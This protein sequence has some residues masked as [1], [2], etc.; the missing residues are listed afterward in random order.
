MTELNK[1]TEEQVYE[2]WVNNDIFQKS[3]EVNKSKK[4]FKF[5][6]GPPFMSG[7]M[8]YG[9]ILAGMIKDSVLRYFHN[10]GFQVYRY[11]SIDCHGL[12]I[13]YEIEK[14][15]GIKT[16]QQVL[17]YGIKNY[18]N[19]CE[20]IVL[21]C[22]DK[23]EEQNGRLGRW[24]DYKNLFKTMDLNFMNSVWWVFAELYKKNRVYE[25]VR[26]MPYSTACGTPLSNFE[27]GQNYK[28][29]QDDSLYVKFKII[30]NEDSWLLCNEYSN[31]YF[32]VWTTTPWTLPTNYLLAINKNMN[33]KTIPYF[34]KETNLKELLIV[35]EEKVDE[36]R[37]ILKLGNDLVS[38]HSLR[39]E[40]LIGLKYEPLFTF[41]NLHNDYKVIHADY[42]S[43]TTGTGIVHISPTHG[44]ED[45]KACLENNYITKESKLFTT[46]DANGYIN[47]NIPEL[48]GA[49]YKNH[50]KSDN[51]DL[52]TWVIKRLKENNQFLLKKTIN[53]EYPFCWR[54]DTPLIYN[55]VNSWFVR[56]EDMREKLVELNN[57]INWVPKSVGES[58][59]S[60]WL[61]DARDWGIS[62]NRF[63]GTP[64]P[65]WKSSTGKIICISSS[66]ELERLA[67]LDYGSITN[68][69]RQFVDEIEIK[70][71]GE[72][73][74]RVEFVF[75][76][77]LESGAMPYGTVGKV[78][79]V[80]LLE[81]HCTKPDSGLKFDSD[82]NPYIQTDNYIYDDNHTTPIREKFSIL[83]ADFIAEGLDQTRG[84]FYTL[85]VLSASL[86]DMISFKN[87]IVNGLILAEDG[88][89]M[90]KRLKNY[91][92]PMDI[93]K[94]YGSDALRLY[95]LGS[96]ATKAEALKFTKSGVHETMKDIIIPLSNTIIFWKEYA[97]LYVKTHKSNPVFSLKLNQSKINNPINLWI[98]KKYSELRLE[99][100]SW[101]DKYELKNSVGILY[102]LVQILNNGYIKMGRNF[103]KG[104][105]SKE[106]WEESLSVMSY[107]IGFVLNDFKSIIPFFC[108]S[109]YLELK[110]F[111]LNELNLT[112]NFDE[113]IHL[114][115]SQE[116]IQLN[117]KQEACS[118][119]FDIIYN[120]I[121]QIYQLRSLND[122]SLKKPV[123]SVQLMWDESLEMRY[124]S[125][126][127]NYLNMVCEECN[128]LNLELIEK[129]QVKITKTIVPVKA[130]FF[131]KYGKSVQDFYELLMSL[132]SEKLEEIIRNNPIDYKS[133]MY[134]IDPTMFNYTYKI[135]LM[136]LNNNTANSNNLIYREFNFGPSKDKIVLLMDKTWDNSTDKIYYYRLI[137]TSIQKARKEARLHPWDKI[138][139]LWEGEPKYSLC[140]NEALEYIEKITRIKLS[141]Y[142]D[143]NSNTIYSE[144]FE[145]I[146][147]KIYLNKLTN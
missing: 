35:V 17:D 49:F 59:F 13:E 48:K 38:I 39:G 45:Y 131:K 14:E 118:V 78:G 110:D 6:D 61:G 54:S 130:L 135:E 106:E 67:G 69:H 96:Q 24:L 70:K 139:A 80:E 89:K 65:I 25:G 7:E 79:I 98:L 4:M 109:K 100:I 111:Y 115:E 40:E 23:W 12:P 19:A 87:V 95:L 145:N 85:L 68:L 33:Y 126:F 99:F 91:P 50:T 114:V 92:D 103:I 77:W 102:K 29:I 10:K 21:R 127:K 15:L 93:V 90:S 46:L 125:K 137:A 128:L 146:G 55:A 113:S 43:N 64:I 82:N 136:E 3:N 66:Y 27:K 122:I 132:D 8:H 1:M 129:D 105:E 30:N 133:T 75:D 124:S 47:D 120:I 83:P 143:F 16:T 37:K 119:D 60:N 94:E 81:K 26:I 138:I 88:K 11:P 22:A 63:W 62:R 142:P 53:H 71:D 147:I 97:C 121:T 123:K 9:H 112:S 20:S 140:S 107:I 104:K 76:C 58:R 117:E 34:N 36:I 5:T 52:N 74:K 44:E 2:Y 101:M 108:E 18:N 141:T 56:V 42:V 144:K 28:E 32:I 116:Y 31:C 86:F 84:W 72:I 57:Q 51:D 41:N 73:Y 134:E